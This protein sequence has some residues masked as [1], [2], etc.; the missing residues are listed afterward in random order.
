MPLTCV[1]RCV[2][3]V[4]PPTPPP[5]SLSLL[6]RQGK[7]RSKTVL[8]VPDICNQGAAGGLEGR[9]EQGEHRDPKG[10]RCG[11]QQRLCPSPIWRPHDGLPS[12]RQNHL[13]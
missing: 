2:Y 11:R 5:S 6:P 9:A 10:C 4:E 7:T 8:L 1:F 12:A 13:F 3:N